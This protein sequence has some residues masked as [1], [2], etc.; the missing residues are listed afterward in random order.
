VMYQKF[1]YQNVISK[2]VRNLV[3]HYSSKISHFVRDN[4]LHWISQSLRPFEMTR[5]L[6]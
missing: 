1:S 5:G 6:I 4:A 3:F 2:V